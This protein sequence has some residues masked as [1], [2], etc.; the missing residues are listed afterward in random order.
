MKKRQNSFEINRLLNSYSN[1][2]CQDDI[3]EVN[4]VRLNNSGNNFRLFR[5]Q[6]GDNFV[7]NFGGNSVEGDASNLQLG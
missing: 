2:T 6:F 1:C 5:G 3:H 7:D 4:F